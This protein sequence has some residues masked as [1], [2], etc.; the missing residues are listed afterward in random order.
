VSTKNLFPGSRFLR[1]VVARGWSWLDSSRRAVFGLALNLLFVLLL[2]ALL[3][4]VYR[5]LRSGPPALQDKTA[6]VLNFS[7]ALVEQSTAGLRQR[8][9]AQARGQDTQDQTRLRDVLAV[10]SAATQDPQITHAV[11]MLDNFAG[12]GL[13]QLREVALA[14]Q[15]FKAAGKPIYAWGSNYD[16]RQYFLAAQAT[17][18]WLH[19]MGTLLVEGYGRSRPYYKELLERVGVSA[20]VI[21]AGKYKNAGETYTASGPSPETQEADALVYGTLWASYTANVESARKLPA[22]SISQTINGLPASLLQAG[23]DPA[24]W[25]VQQKWVDALR[26]SDEARV[27][28][29]ERGAAD[30]KDKTFRQIGFDAYLARIK[31]AQQGPAVAVV[32]AQGVISD[33]RAGA[34]AVGGLST[35]ELIRKARENADVKALVLRVNSPGGSAFGSELV[36][37]EL[38]ITRQ[39]GKPV[40]V[41]MGDV[42]ASGGYWI[43]MAADEIWADEATV[44]GSI[45]VVSLLPTAQGA[46][47]KLGIRMAGEGTTWLANA[48]DPKKGLD[49]RF[50]QLMQSA[51][52]GTYQ[53][54]I[55][56]VA[57][58]RKSNVPAIDALAQGRVWAGK[59][60]QARGLVDKLGGLADAVQAAGQRAK[61]VA[62]TEA[63][64]QMSTMAGYRVLYIEATPG[65]LDRWLRRLGV[66]LETVL[67]SPVDL[68]SLALALGVLPA[69]AE[70]LAQ[71]MA[72]LAQAAKQASARPLAAATHCLCVAPE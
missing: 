24:R 26:T 2:G 62:S 43:S 1:S 58:A 61:L 57:G 3:L 18:V 51:V 69:A 60:A 38:D 72:W 15:R 19:P 27:V 22:G 71:D 65:R 68:S 33:G 40:V 7:G 10:L 63:S 44:T 31:P 64:T 47:D 53:R 42:A 52:D 9:L 21:R 30:E 39:A 59:D 56:L 66:G 8:A 13:P 36:R 46:L 16:Q 45:G 25:A 41:S 17:E 54:F 34:G 6:L 12:A 28:L 5:A 11:L 67:G 32:V 4:G 49:P 55:S 50:A 20:N 37:R 48:Y 35:A 29:V 70:E 14:L 23:N